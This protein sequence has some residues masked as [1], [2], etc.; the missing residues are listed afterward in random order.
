MQKKSRQVEPA[1]IFFHS[2][3]PACSSRSTMARN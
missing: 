3:F 1:G 2:F